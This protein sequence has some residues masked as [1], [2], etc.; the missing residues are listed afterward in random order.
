MTAHLAHLYAML[1]PMAQRIAV[2]VMV[3]FALSW[4]AAVLFGR[5]LNDKE[6]R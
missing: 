1:A 2:G 3:M 4:P 6:R 5:F